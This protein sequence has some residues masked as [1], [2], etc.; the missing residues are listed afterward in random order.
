MVDRPRAL[1]VLRKVVLFL[2]LELSLGLLLFLVFL[3]P[4][5]SR[6]FSPTPWDWG[7]VVVFVVLYIFFVYFA[8]LG[9][10]GEAQ[11]PRP[12]SPAEASGPQAAQ[13]PAALGMKNR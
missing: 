3:L 13:E 5:L 9:P 4:Q 6:D 2:V 8:V 1:A 11:S 10:K 12:P 7:P